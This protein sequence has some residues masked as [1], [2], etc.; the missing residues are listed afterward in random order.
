[1][2]Y[3]SFIPIGFFIIGAVLGNAQRK[4]RESYQIKFIDSDKMDSFFLEE[5][6]KIDKNVYCSVCGCKITRDTI[7]LLTKKDGKSVYVCR[8]TH[9][10]NLNR[11]SK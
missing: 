6:I 5:N 2:I 8:K 11:V 1:M 7:G 4:K 10:T 9:C 3:L